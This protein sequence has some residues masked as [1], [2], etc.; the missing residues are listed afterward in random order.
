MV[1]IKIILIVL[2]IYSALKIKIVIVDFIESSRGSKQ[3]LI[4]YVGMYVLFMVLG[5]ISLIDIIFQGLN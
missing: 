4:R 5:F 2:G 3:L 1:F